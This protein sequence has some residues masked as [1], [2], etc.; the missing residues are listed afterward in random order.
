MFEST[1]INQYTNII[2]REIAWVPEPCGFLFIDFYSFFLLFAIFLQ[3][4]FSNLSEK[5]G[6]KRGWV[7]IVN[8]KTNLWFITQNDRSKLAVN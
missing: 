2:S 8:L 7:L 3:F 4:L 5:M 6:W 1:S